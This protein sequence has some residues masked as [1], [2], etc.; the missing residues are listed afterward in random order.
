[1][2]KQLQ[3][4]MIL[5]AKCFHDENIIWGLGG[6][7]LLDLLGL[8]VS[9]NDLDIMVEANDFDKA[10]DILSHIGEE[11]HKAFNPNFRTARFKTFLVDECEVDVMSGISVFN[12]SKWFDFDFT[13]SKIASKIFKDSIEIPLMALEDWHQIYQALQREEKVDL[14]DR[15]MNEKGKNQ[16]HPLER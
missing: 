9:V 14:I 5:I 6:S 8:K 10:I 3:T 11:K 13:V 2:N 16:Q 1:M 4:T 15:Y 12:A 7:A